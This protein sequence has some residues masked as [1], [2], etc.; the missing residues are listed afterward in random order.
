MSRKWSEL[1]KG[2][3]Y[4]LN[5]KIVQLVFSSN[6]GHNLMPTNRYHRVQR[7]H[8]RLL[9]VKQLNNHMSAGVLKWGSERKFIRLYD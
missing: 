3:K 2:F 9:R 8:V 5:R 4:F 7:V 1:F 6:F